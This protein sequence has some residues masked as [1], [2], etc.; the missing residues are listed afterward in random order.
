MPLAPFNAANEF[1]VV[2]DLLVNGKI[3]STDEKVPKHLIR[4]RTLRQL[5]EQRRIKVAESAGGI[6]ENGTPVTVASEPVQC[7]FPAGVVGDAKPNLSGPGPR[8]VKPKPMEPRIPPDW[9]DWH[10][11]VQAKKCAELGYER[12]KNGAEAAAI[13]EAE[14]NA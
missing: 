14:E 3:Y 11:Q 2:S 8:D 10:W 5:Y 7:R 12:P 9:R 1:V 6:V 13:L 4:V